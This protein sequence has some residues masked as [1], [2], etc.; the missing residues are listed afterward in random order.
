ML[1]MS[2]GAPVST[3]KL[4]SVLSHFAFIAIR[5]SAL[6]KGIMQEDVSLV[7]TGSGYFSNFYTAFE[8]IISISISH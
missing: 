5:L 6:L 1:R 3:I 2:L 8:N 7:A 4:P